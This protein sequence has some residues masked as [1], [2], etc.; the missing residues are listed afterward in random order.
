MDGKRQAGP[1][2]ATVQFEHFS[3][4][5]ARSGR[6][7]AVR[8]GTE[9]LHTTDIP[10]TFITLEAK[11]EPSDAV[12]SLPLFSHL[13]PGHF[14]DHDLAA[15]GIEETIDFEDLPPE[16]G[17]VHDEAHT[18]AEG[19]G[20][21][22]GCRVGISGYDIAVSSKSMCVQCLDIG[23]PAEH[24]KIK[25]GTARFLFR[26]RRNAP[27]RSLHVACVRSGSI[28][29]FARGTKEHWED[30][31]RWLNEAAELHASDADL[32]AFFIEISNIFSEHLSGP[33]SASGSSS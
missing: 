8:P 27:E 7:F 3:F 29:D 17:H 10:L 28:L 5:S 2:I 14:D 21:P 26:P 4:E 30:S 22:S 31:I 12:S 1:D 33:G 13:V 6:K 32:R 15:E 19:I 18:V 25:A 9:I 24:A 23:L 11:R 20:V 16:V